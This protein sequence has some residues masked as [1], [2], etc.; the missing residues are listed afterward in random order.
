[1]KKLDIAVYWKRGFVH[2]E[3]TE[4]GVGLWMWSVHDHNQNAPQ[5][6]QGELQSR[7]DFQH[8]IVLHGVQ[9]DE[10]ECIKSINSIEYDTFDSVKDY[11]TEWWDWLDKVCVIKPVRPDKWG[12]KHIENDAKTNTI[13][14][15]QKFPESIVEPESI[16]R[17]LRD[18]SASG[19]M[20]MYDEDK[21]HN[22]VT[23]PK[24]YLLDDDGTQLKDLMPKLIGKFQGS[25]AAHMYN[26][27]KYVVRHPEKDGIKDLRKAKQEINAL[28]KDTY[29]VDENE[30]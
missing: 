28:I 14:I 22:P 30:D 16:K 24:W 21:G 11:P 17:Y 13:N 19:L 29:G 20:G 8:T 18:S 6:L 7:L 27:I 5:A 12:R 23:K 10:R 1:M 26:I 2:S 15:T 9:F 4:T 25:K 3:N